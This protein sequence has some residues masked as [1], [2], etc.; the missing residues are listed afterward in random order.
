MTVLLLLCLKVQVFNVKKIENF[1][2]VFNDK[3]RKSP[4]TGL[5]DMLL[6]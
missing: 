4:Q 1:N 2:G 3:K 5:V 6:A